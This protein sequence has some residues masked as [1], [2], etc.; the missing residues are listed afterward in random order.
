MRIDGI[1]RPEG[2]AVSKVESGLAVTCAALLALGIWSIVRAR[3]VTQY[4][5]II[6]S[7]TL[8]NLIVLTALFCR[9]RGSQPAQPQQGYLIRPGDA[10][11]GEAGR[12][13]L[14]PLR[15]AHS[16][17]CSLSDEER[18][19][20][21]PPGTADRA[22]NGL[23]R[24]PQGAPV[25]VVGGAVADVEEPIPQCPEPAV[26]RHQVVASILRAAR[27]FLKDPIVTPS[28]ASVARTKEQ[29]ILQTQIGSN[30]LTALRAQREQ[31]QPVVAGLKRRRDEAGEQA[32]IFYNQLHD[33]AAGRAAEERQ[34]ALS[35]AVDQHLTLI[36]D[37]SIDI[38]QLEQ[39]LQPRSD[40]AS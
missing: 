32:R 30:Q 13:E 40:N 19:Q 4:R 2:R 15:G 20:D 36:R 22:S 31:L 14:G 28:A 11:S 16:Q 24:Y 38:E 18:L 3:T 33:R 37:I 27:D 5:A 9:S 21:R 25:P 8:V 10:M 23:T 6:A 12:G 29:I 1:V 17:P 34:H 26:P 39:A 35:R 7:L